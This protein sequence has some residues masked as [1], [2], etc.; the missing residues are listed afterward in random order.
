MALL[1]EQ[2]DVIRLLWSQPNV[3]FDG[4]FHHL[5]GVGINPLPD[6]STSP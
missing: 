5:H 2:I 4:R 3:D 1:E 6:A